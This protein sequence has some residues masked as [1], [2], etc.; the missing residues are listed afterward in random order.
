[1]VVIACVFGIDW[2]GRRWNDCRLGIGWWWSFG[3]FFFSFFYLEHVKFNEYNLR[4]LSSAI[5]LEIVM[6]HRICVSVV[7]FGIWVCFGLKS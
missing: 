2:I 1:M 6:M 3:F 7:V 5:T 4:L